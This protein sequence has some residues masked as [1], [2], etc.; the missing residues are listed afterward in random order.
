MACQVQDLTVPP[1]SPPKPPRRPWLRR[2]ST[3]G[4]GCRKDGCWIRFYFL[5]QTEAEEVGVHCF[6]TLRNVCVFVARWHSGTV[7]CRRCHVAA[8]KVPSS[9][10]AEKWDSETLHL[11]FDFDVCLL[12]THS[13]W[14]ETPTRRER[15]SISDVFFRNQ[16]FKVNLIWRGRYQKAG[17][18][19]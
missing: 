5:G 14:C 9:K 10:R 8:L 6:Q 15:L 7:A 1:P 18:T 19:C 13:I 11:V 3:S 12:H 2:V 4:L 16:I 17:E